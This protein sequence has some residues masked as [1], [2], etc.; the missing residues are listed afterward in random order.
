MKTFRLDFCLEAWVNNLE[1]E[2]ENE[3]EAI[4]KLKNMAL[5]EIAVNGSERQTDI[6]DNI[7]CEVVEAEYEIEVYN[8]VVKDI[9]GYRREKESQFIKVHWY[10]G[11]DLEQKIEWNLDLE[12]GYEVISFDYNIINE[13]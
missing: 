6:K 3:K 5:S 7:D 10:E 8:L 12:E 13:D 4:E 1:I 11:D 9:N 2:A